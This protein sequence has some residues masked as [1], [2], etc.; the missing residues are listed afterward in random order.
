MSRTLEQNVLKSAL[1]LIVGQDKGSKARC[2]RRYYA[3]TVG[4]G[5][6]IRV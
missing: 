5:E 6:L 4:E 3:G 1:G 2:A